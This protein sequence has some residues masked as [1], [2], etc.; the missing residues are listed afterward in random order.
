MRVTLF[1]FAAI[2]TVLSVP[3]WARPSRF[4][5]ESTD[6]LADEGVVTERTAAGPR[7]EYQDGYGFA[8]TLEPNVRTWKRQWRAERRA[9]RLLARQEARRGAAVSPKDNPMPRRVADQLPPYW[10]FA[11]PSFSPPWLT[12]IVPAMLEKPAMLETLSG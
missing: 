9:Q 3:A 6:G 5:G 1:L 2:A 11:E 8:P 10:A 7:L 12:E 4:R